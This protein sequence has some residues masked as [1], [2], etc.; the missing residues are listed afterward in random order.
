MVPN[1][2]I[3]LRNVDVMTVKNIRELHRDSTASIAK[4]EVGNSGEVNG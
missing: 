4:Q 1:T 2:A 3:E